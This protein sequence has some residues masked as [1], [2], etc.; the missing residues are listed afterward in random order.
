MDQAVESYILSTI[1]GRIDPYNVYPIA[2]EATKMTESNLSIRKFTRRT[3]DV[4]A[5][6]VT[7]RNLD[8]VAAWC[9]GKIIT[10]KE[11]VE[12]TDG[13]SSSV[14]RRHISVEVARPL[15]RSQTEAHV[16]DWVLYASKGFK[17]YGNRP[18]QKNFFEKAEEEPLE[19]LLVTNEEPAVVTV[20]DSDN[21]VNIS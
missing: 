13:E 21:P 2:K 6:R 19:E 17:V 1:S 10:V 8:A 14:S 5:V 18:F 9:N 16:G 11:S 15:S 12:S 4:D 7:E 3:F 20:I